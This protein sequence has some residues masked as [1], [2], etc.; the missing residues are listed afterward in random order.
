[1]EIIIRPAMPEDYLETE[2][3]TREAFWNHFSPGCDEHYLLHIMR[4]CPAFIPELDLVAEYS[5]RIVGHVICVKSVI[6]GD[7]GKDYDV[8][9]LGPI[10]VLPEY[11]QKKI[12][13]K[14]IETVRQQAH[15]MG[16]RAILLYGDPDY[17]RRQGFIPAE[18]LDIRTVD[19]M[20]AVALYACELYECSLLFAKGNFVEDAIYMVDADAAAEYD[21]NF[22]HKEKVSGTPS[23]KRFQ[24][25]VGM[26]KALTSA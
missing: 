3:V 2:N 23:Q 4:K 13:G 7:D 22:P 17:Y 14:L 24:M 19:N 6:K 25:I 21:K 8:L 15:K 10:S 1:M 5:G 11:Q 12:G 16:F 9:T 20:Y 26:R 18:Q